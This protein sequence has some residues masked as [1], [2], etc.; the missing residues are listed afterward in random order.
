MAEGKITIETAVDLA[1]F[2]S[3]L[4]QLKKLAASSADEVEKELSDIDVDF[5][6]KAEDAA[7]GIRDIGGAAGEAGKQSQS[8]GSS[9]GGLVGQIGG[10]SLAIV[11]GKKALELLKEGY[12]ETTK[13]SMEFETAITGIYKTVDASDVVLSEITQ[14]IK[15]LSLELPVTTTELAAIAEAA[16]QLGIAAEDIV[17]FTEVMAKMAATTNLSSEEAATSLAKM[18][19]ITQM[20]PANYEKLGS[21]IVKL[22]NTYATT[23]ADIVALAT[24]LASTAEVAGFTEAEMLALAAAV[25][26][27]GIEA[28]AG[29]TAVSKL[30][31]EMQSAAV[32]GE[33]AQKILAET[34]Y[35]LREL[36]MMADNNADGFKELANTLGYT[37]GEFKD[38]LSQAQNLEKFAEVA[39]MTADAFASLWDSSPMEAMNAF[40]NGLG[41]IQAAGGDAL[42]ILNDLGLTEIRLSNAV[43]ALSTATGVL[44]ETQQTANQAW[45]E[46]TALSDEYAQKLETLEAKTE[47]F[48][49]AWSRVKVAVGDTNKEMNKIAVDFGTEILS[50]IARKIESRSFNVNVKLN[51]LSDQGVAI[52]VDK[53][54]VPEDVPMPEGVQIFEFDPEQLTVLEESQQAVS[55]ASQSMLQ[56]VNEALAAGT[57][58][59]EKL[60]ATGRTTED[61]A[62]MM[63]EFGQQAA[64]AFGKLDTGADS[65][66]TLDQMME[67]LTANQEAMR[68]WGDNMDALAQRMR[69]FEG[70]Q[71]VVEQFRQMGIEGAAQLQQLMNATDEELAA[72]AA[73]VQEGLK[74]SVEVGL[75]VSGADLTTQFEEQLAPIQAQLEGY[76]KL[77]EG[78]L[79]SQEQFEGLTAPLLEEFKAVEEEAGAASAA[80]NAEMN[81]AYDSAM[82]V[83]GNAGS[84]GTAMVDGIAAGITSGG[85]G[86]SSA[87]IKELNDA[88]KEGKDAIESKSPS[89]KTKRLIGKPM[90]QGVGVGIIEDGKKAAEDMKMVLK[91]IIRTGEM[92]TRELIDNARAPAYSGR[93]NS[94]IGHLISSSNSYDQRYNQVVNFYTPVE[95]PSAVARKIKEVQKLVAQNF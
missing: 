2:K 62:N 61:L 19:N 87:L 40:I 22:G 35:T 15:D 44:A 91:Y 4:A 28:E 47:L 94:T 29:G 12:I 57:S 64:D 25:S 41:N 77:F 33:K 14:G 60:A 69:D 5:G 73:K 51:A 38:M 56:A 95:S 59:D 17:Y 53:V 86:I 93:E 84:I 31:K 82:T 24:R 70:G 90:I 71:Y 1:G 63:V 81:A 37:S 8:L 34:G 26:S 55:A 80:V 78:G 54:V 48:K 16:G 27:V 74:L 32:S 10:V 36:E 92:E 9:L 85:S 58:L 6:D 67:N 83:A 45:Q 50:D 23:E 39:G 13:A 49:N 75:E 79:I 3:D 11:A 18:A 88:M 46:G 52:T 21:A 43:L 42:G 72:L 7:D 30:I 76:K 65:V 68:A 89:K 66:I 20:D